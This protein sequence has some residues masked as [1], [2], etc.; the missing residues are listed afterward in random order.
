MSIDLST[1]S[2]V[3]AAMFCRIDV[4]DYDVLLFSNYNI[5][6][7]INGESYVN[8]GT[9]LGITD[10]TSDL[11]ATS[12]TLTI[13]ISGIPDSSISEVLTQRFKGSKI[14]VWRV[15][16]DANTKQI[17]GIDGNPAGRFQGIVTNWSLAEDWTPGGHTSSNRIDFTCS[18][19]VDVLSNK[20]A[21][22]KTNSKDQKKYFP[23]DLSMDRVSIITKSNFNFG[24]VVK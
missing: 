20:V 1:Y 2:A 6:V 5:P 17:L 16:F 10:S 7:S 23:N 21:G 13:T 14:Q 9:L 22:R 18:S 24:A 8:L 4:P 15:F 11:R 3:E 19:T 12:G